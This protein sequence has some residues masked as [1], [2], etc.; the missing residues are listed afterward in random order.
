MD[1]SQIVNVELN[2]FYM[3]YRDAEKFLELAEEELAKDKNGRL[4][5][6]FSRHCLLSTVF[7]SE[8]LINRVYAEF[9]IG[10]FDDDTFNTINKLSIQEKWLLAP[11]F[12]NAKDITKTFNKGENVFQTFVELVKIRNSWVHPKPGIYVN[13]ERVGIYFSIENEIAPDVKVLPNTKYWPHTKIPLNPFELNAKHA[14][15]VFENLNAMIRR[16]L[17][18]FEGVFDKPWMEKFT[19]QIGDQSVKSHMKVHWLSGGGYTP[20]SQ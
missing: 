20:H 4:I 14:R 13:G 8:A 19:I 11:K 2:F 18:I 3:H 9:Y 7:A 15:L 6:Y 5:S 16:L 12:C 17:V 1:S 10:K